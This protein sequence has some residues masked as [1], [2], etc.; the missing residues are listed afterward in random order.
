M[1]TI[2]SATAK[3]VGE[4]IPELKGRMTGMSLRVPTANVSVVDL[5]ARLRTTA[6]YRDVCVAMENAAQHSMKGIITCTSGPVVSSDI[7]GFQQTGIFDE[8]AGIMLDDNLVKCIAWY[9]NEW[10]YTNKLI[11]LITHMHSVN[12]PRR[13]LR[14]RAMGQYYI[15]YCPIPMQ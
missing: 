1:S 7:I 15:R 14:R 11:D 13:H 2:H 12:H 8:T 10:G 5:T 3:A 4:V 6:S 9:D